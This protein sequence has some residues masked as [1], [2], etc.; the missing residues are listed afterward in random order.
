MVVQVLTSTPGTYTGA[1]GW[2]C[3]AGVQTVIAR[4]RGAG[5][6]SGGGQTFTGGGAGGGG[7]GHSEETLHVAPGVRYDFQIGSGG[8][9]GTSPAG[10]G[11]SPGGTLAD[12]WFMSAADCMAKGGTP[13][14][15]GA[16]AA[17]VGGAAASG[18]GSVK[19]SGGNGATY[20]G[21]AGGGGGGSA[22]SGGNG[23]TAPTSSGAGGTA[24]AGTLPGVAGSPGL[25]SGG[26]VGLARGGGAGASVAAP[27]TGK[28]GGVG[29]IELEYDPTESLNED[30]GL[31]D[32][33]TGL[34][35]PFDSVGKLNDAYDMWWGGQV[36]DVYL[37]STRVWNWVSVIPYTVAITPAAGFP[38]EFIVPPGCTE[39]AFDAGGGSG[40]GGT[41]TS[42]GGDGQLLSGVFSVTAGQVLRG[43]VARAGA[44]ASVGDPH[45]QGGEPGGAAST[46][47]TFGQ[48]YAQLGGTGGG[49][50]SIWRDYELVAVAAGGGGG[51]SRSSA[52]VGGNG[53]MGGGLVGAA[54]AAG[55]FTAAGLQGTGGGGGTQSAGG[56]GG[57]A[58]SFSN[59]P[60]EHAF[61]GKFL[62]GGTGFRFGP[63][64]TGSL[65]HA[66]GGGGGGGYYG[67]GGGGNGSVGG[68]SDGGGGGGGGGSQFVHPDMTVTVNT[69]GGNSGHGF[70]TLTFYAKR[71]YS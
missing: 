70:L 53:G 43:Y 44:T 24:G 8:T 61:P 35:V 4:V 51:G 66:C 55:A 9:G 56:A 22:G 48:E 19:F 31:T 62:A 42:L 18:F 29:Y 52:S 27:S 64:G 15:G 58:G 69:P 65:T 33:T 21:G 32:T 5:G 26:T 23:G 41:S 49:L 20:A 17:G 59:G 2:L 39:I 67:G 13:G 36:T 28:A 68:L 71:N 11:T 40:G 16:G 46:E 3:P 1:S 6:P 25:V 57:V 37:G 45:G 10:N 30:V 60:N 34:L 14:L 50:T 54:G 63:Y 47:N 12:S 38:F 7:G